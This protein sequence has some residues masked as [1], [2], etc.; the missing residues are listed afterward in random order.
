MGMDKQPDES[1]EVTVCVGALFRWCSELLFI[2]DYFTRLDDP[3]RNHRLTTLHDEIL[4]LI[5]QARAD[6]TR[7]QFGIPIIG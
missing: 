2:R 3:G 5:E 4:A 1:E 6:P 7:Q